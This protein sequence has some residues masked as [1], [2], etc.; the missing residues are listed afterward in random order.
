M[1]KYRILTIDELFICFDFSTQTITNFNSL[2]S[3]CLF[4][5]NNL[6]TVHL[7]GLNFLLEFFIKFIDGL[8][9]GEGLLDQ[10]NLRLTLFSQ[11][12][13]LSDQQGQYIV[14]WLVRGLD[15]N[16]GEVLNEN[17]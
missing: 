15:V 4:L 16:D 3:L 7:N 6:S 9:L 5:A 14:D 11:Q 1:G 2:N 13:I 10:H 17:R 12:F 8:V